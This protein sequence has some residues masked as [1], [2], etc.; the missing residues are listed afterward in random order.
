MKGNAYK[1][2]V[3]PAKLLCLEMMAPS[4]RQESELE[5]VELLMLG[6]SHGVMRMD[7]IRNKLIRWTAQVR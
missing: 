4:K 6:F 3:K 7:R 1:R 5:V 2:V